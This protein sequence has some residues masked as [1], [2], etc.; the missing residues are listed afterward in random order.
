MINPTATPNIDQL[1]QVSAARNFGIGGISELKG[2]INIINIHVAAGE[3]I[4]Q[5]VE[6]IAS[7]LG[8]GRK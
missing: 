4:D 5:L 3:S 6:R 2:N 1:T 8:D 7:I